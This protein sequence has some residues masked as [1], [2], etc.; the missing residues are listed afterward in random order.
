MTYVQRADKL[1]SLTGLEWTA[2]ESFHGAT[3]GKR[4]YTLRL[5]DGVWHA[6]VDDLESLYPLFDKS[7]TWDEVVGWILKRLEMEAA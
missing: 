7:G 4:R 5:R 6:C 2:A 3:D 1:R